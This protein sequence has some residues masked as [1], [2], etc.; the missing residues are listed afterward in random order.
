MS[1]DNT[2]HCGAKPGQ[3][4][5]YHCDIARCYWTGEQMMQCGIWDEEGSRRDHDCSPSVWDG[6]FP[7]K[8]KCAEYGLYTTVVG[9]EGPTEDLTTISIYGKWNVDTQQ[10]EIDEETLKKL[11]ERR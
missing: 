9:I 3:I 5:K 6:A 10:N 7:G 2:H 11:K 8:K 4:H 1:E